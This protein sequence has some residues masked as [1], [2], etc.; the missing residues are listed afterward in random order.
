M[1]K[2]S[3]KLEKAAELF[4]LILVELVD[5]RHTKKKK[6]KDSSQKLPGNAPEL[7]EKKR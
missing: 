5:S 4:A 7:D 3:T 2:Q 1:S 6:N